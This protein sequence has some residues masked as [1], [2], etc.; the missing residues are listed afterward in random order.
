MLP[1]SGESELRLLLGVFKALGVPFTMHCHPSYSDTDE[2]HKAALKAA[3]FGLSHDFLNGVCVG[4]I[5]LVFSV[6]QPQWYSE[7]HA[8]GPTGAFLYAFNMKTKEVRMR[9]CYEG[10]DLVP[11]LQGLAAMQRQYGP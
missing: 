8:W 7:D 2:H 3:G 1:K 5:M 10:G 4:D 6:G 11:G 9:A